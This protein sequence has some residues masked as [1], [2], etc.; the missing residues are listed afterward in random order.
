MNGAMKACMTAVAL[1]APGE[2]SARDEK[3]PAEKSDGAKAFVGSI[4]V[5][6]KHRE[7]VIKL[8]NDRGFRGTFVPEDAAPGTLLYRGPKTEYEAAV[9][10]VWKMRWDDKAPQKSD[11]DDKPKSKDAKTKRLDAKPDSDAA[12]LEKLALSPLQKELCDE[13]LKECDR[14]MVEFRENP[15]RT[16]EMVRKG[17]EFNR[18]K[19]GTLRT[20][21]TRDQYAGYCGAFGAK[22]SDADLGPAENLKPVD[23]QEPKTDDAIFARLGL[24]AKQKEYLDLHRAWMEKATA[25]MKAAPSGHVEAGAKLNGKWRAGLDRILTKSQRKQYLDYWGPPPGNLVG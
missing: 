7:A 1:L 23:P 9:E 6:E 21:L 24:S 17:Q 8:L 19:M 14:R 12:A 16:P 15:H 4:Q 25:E 3:P 2:V 11:A 5:P 22:A 13:W 18:W 20:I 10:I